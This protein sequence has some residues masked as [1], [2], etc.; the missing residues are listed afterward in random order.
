NFHWENHIH[1][2][3]HAVGNASIGG[4]GALSAGGLILKVGLVDSLILRRQRSLLSAP[5][6]LARVPLI[7]DTS[8]SLPLARPVGILGFVMRLRGGD[9]REDHRRQDDRTDR[10]PEWH[11]SSHS[12]VGGETEDKSTARPGSVVR[13]SAWSCSR[14]KSRPVHRCATARS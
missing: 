12:A 7:A 5:R 13:P 4:V 1:C 3:R 10:P 2:P 11:L 6:R 14:T 9:R 8:G